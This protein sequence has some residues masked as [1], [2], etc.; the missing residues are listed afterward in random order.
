MLDRLADANRRRWN[1]MHVN[2]AAIPGLDRVASRLLKAKERYQAVEK[3][4]GV[5]WP[6]IAVIHEREAS[7]AWWA[8]LAQGDRWD[9]VSRHIPRGQGPFKS[10]EQ[11]AVNALNHSAPFLGRNK[12]WSV[13][14]TLAQLEAYNGLGYQKM[15]KP[16]PYIWAKTSEYRS[17]KYVADGVYSATAI[18]TQDGC[19][20][21][22]MRMMNKDSTINKQY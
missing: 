21:L 14:M 5:P 15:G 9:R 22:L 4:T 20:A 7:Q 1:A 8:N 17:G 19:A 16:S 10:W 12:D 18:D 6:V 2:V 3:L 13:G 11:A